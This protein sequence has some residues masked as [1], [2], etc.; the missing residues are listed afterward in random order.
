MKLKEMMDKHNEEIEKQKA[1]IEKQARELEQQEERDRQR[2]QEESAVLAA[3]QEQINI[4]NT[5][6]TSSSHVKDHLIFK[7]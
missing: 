2:R 4:L 1:E 5:R 6:R 3:M 7:N